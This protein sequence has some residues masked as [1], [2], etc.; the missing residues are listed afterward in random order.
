MEIADSVYDTGQIPE[1]MAQSIII[2]IPKKPG[3]VDCDKF[4]AISGISQLSNIALKI[5]RKRLGSKIEAEVE[6]EQFGF[7]K[8][9]GT[10]NAIFIVRM[11]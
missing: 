8:G 11:L 7:M 1:H 5:L 6:E 3:A 2:T 9:I 4:R 10:C